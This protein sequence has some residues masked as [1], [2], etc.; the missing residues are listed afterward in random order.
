[1]KIKLKDVNWYP[2]VVNVDKHIVFIQTFLSCLVGI[3]IWNI[4][5]R[6]CFY[7]FVCNQLSC[8]WHKTDASRYTD[9]WHSNKT[10]FYCRFL[11][12]F[13]GIHPG[14]YRIIKAYVLLI[15]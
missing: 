14:N 5:G 12:R 9:E 3:F 11:S 7:V 1:M 2:T 4:S 10:Y 8:V 13:V 6:Q 15:F